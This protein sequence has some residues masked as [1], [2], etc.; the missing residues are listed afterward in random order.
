[1]RAQTKGVAASGTGFGSDSGVEM[2]VVVNN[3]ER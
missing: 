3:M 1:M 2:P